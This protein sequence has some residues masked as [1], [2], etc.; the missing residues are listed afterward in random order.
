MLVN[1]PGYFSVAHRTIRLIVNSRFGKRSTLTSGFPGPS[2]TGVSFLVLLNGHHDSKRGTLDLTPFWKSNNAFHRSTDK[3]VKTF[4][5]FGATYPE[6][7]GLAE[8]ASDAER[9]AVI[10]AKVNALYDGNNRRQ[11]IAVSSVAAAEDRQ[12]PL[13]VAAAAVSTARATHVPAPHHAETPKAPAHGHAAPAAPVTLTALQRLDWF[14]RIRVKKFQ[15]KQSFSILFFLGPVPDDVG[16]W[17]S[18]PNLV[19]N[20]SEFVNSDAKSC[21]NCQENIN[22]ITEGFID[23]D[24]SLERKGYGNKSEKEIEKFIRDEIHWRIQ[25]VQLLSFVFTQPRKLTESLD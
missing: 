6:F 22:A 9:Q 15:L 14:I 19:G 10:Q 24:T 8:N 1:S 13:A 4:T 17:R 3:P 20:H 11:G 21:A 25:K 16:Q 23:L 12:A 7:V 18:S 5:E 2:P